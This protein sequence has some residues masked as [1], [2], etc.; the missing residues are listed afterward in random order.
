MFDEL[1]RFAWM[2]VYIAIIAYTFWL[3]EN[4]AKAYAFVP[5]TRKNSQN[6]IN[7]HIYFLFRLLHL[8]ENYFFLPQDRMAWKIV[9]EKTTIWTSIKTAEQPK[10][11][12]VWRLMAEKSFSFTIN[13]KNESSQSSKTARFEQRSEK[14]NRRNVCQKVDDIKTGRIIIVKST[15]S[16]AG[17][18]ITITHIFQ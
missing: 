12:C 11:L 4:D 3:N 16:I 8:L 18:W 15:E 7:A 17:A 5:I 10:T 1:S 9:Q 13:Y 14:K 2:C 6:S